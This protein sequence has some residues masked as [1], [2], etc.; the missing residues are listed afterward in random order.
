M[1]VSFFQGTLGQ[2]EPSPAP[3]GEGRQINAEALIFQMKTYY[4]SPVLPSLTPSPHAPSLPLS[5][6][7]FLSG[8]E[9]ECVLLRGRFPRV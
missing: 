3:Q 8:Q 6:H 9:L 2:K 7:V 4:C 1:P 5:S